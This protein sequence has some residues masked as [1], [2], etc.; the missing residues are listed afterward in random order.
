ML[1]CII[2]VRGETIDAKFLNVIRQSSSSQYYNYYYSCNSCG[3]GIQWEV[4]GESAA[5]HTVTDDI[6]SV[7]YET[8]HNDS[9]ALRFTSVLLGKR[10]KLDD[11]C[12]DAILIVARA[13]LHPIVVICR[14]TSKQVVINYQ[15]PDLS[16]ERSMK[17][18]VV[19]LSFIAGQ[20][21]VISS[22]SSFVTQVFTC[23][24][25]ETSQL[26]ERDNKLA[27]AFN[28]VDNAGSSYYEVHSLDSSVVSREAILLVDRPNVEVTS[29]LI[30]SDFD[31]VN[32]TLSCLSDNS[33]A[34]AMWPLVSTQ[35]VNS[36]SPSSTMYIR[37]T[38][39]SSSSSTMYIRQTSIVYIRQTSA[40]PTSVYNKLK[41]MITLAQSPHCHWVS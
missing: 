14:G 6:G 31:S 11:V 25:S 2:K 4:D 26:W 22:N 24:T 34:S 17:D 15:L 41:P 7:A 38:S 27:G 9:S 37:Q 8:E 32:F 5:T 35:P 18:T 40:G 19:K 20:Q 23:T 36:T 1:I 30:L 33:V 39:T 16:S 3:R 29:V 13:N 10:S 21:G 12:M 28:A